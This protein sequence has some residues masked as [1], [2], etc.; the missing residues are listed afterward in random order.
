M[1]KPCEKSVEQ[2]YKELSEKSGVTYIRYKNEGG[3]LVYLDN[4]SFLKM[5]ELGIIPQ[6]QE[7]EIL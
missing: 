1:C 5:K 6:D 7:A 4:P 3:Q 2:S